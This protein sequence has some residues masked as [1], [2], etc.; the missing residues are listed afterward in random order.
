VARVVEV[1]SGFWIGF[2][3]IMHDLRASGRIADLPMA[4]GEVI[5]LSEH[6]GIRIGRWGPR[7][8]ARD[9]GRDFREWSLEQPNLEQP[10]RAWSRLT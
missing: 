2:S 3:S 5:P 1:N 4:D 6:H 10:L 7:P 9:W 8:R